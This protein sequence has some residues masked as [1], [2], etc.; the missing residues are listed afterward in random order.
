MD[1]IL[2][3]RNLDK[4]RYFKTRNVLCEKCAE[5]YICLEIFRTAK[6]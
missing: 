3:E 1:N 6:K 4:D 5:K 2:S